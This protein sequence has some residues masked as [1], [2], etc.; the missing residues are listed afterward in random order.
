MYPGSVTTTPI[1]APLFPLLAGALEA[2]WHR[3][4]AAAHAGTARCSEILATNLRWK[5]YGPSRETLVVIGAAT[6]FVLAAGAIFALRASRRAR[7]RWEA[8]TLIGLAI[9]PPIFM[10]LSFEFHPED[11]LCVGLLLVSARFVA[12]GRAEAAGVAA[13][14]AVL[15][16]QFALLA[17]VALVVA[18]PRELRVRL[19]AAGA[20]VGVIVLG[21]LAIATS[22]RVLSALGGVGFTPPAGN[23]W[24]SQ[25]AWGHG[26]VFVLSRVVPIAAALATA[27]WARRRLGERLGEP[28]A[29]CALL[30][31]ALAWRLVFEVNLYGYYFMAVVATLIVAVALGGRIRL[32]LL[33][34]IVLIALSYPPFGFAPN[35]VLGGPTGWFEP[36]LLALAGLALAVRELVSVERTGRNPVPALQ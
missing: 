22:G 31:A 32:S 21:A 27:L 3:G 8:L 28:R 5:H 14:A 20:L 16:Q 4:H 18:A 30:A 15:S 7:T 13:A 9:A 6:W 33:A 17:V 1:V 11:L 24:I 29:L 23:T 10:C 2:P 12:T 34:W 25:L 36:L 35:W 19:V 26:G